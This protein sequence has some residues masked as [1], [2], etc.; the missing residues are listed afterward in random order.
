MRHLRITIGI[1]TLNGPDLLARC[2]ESVGACTRWAQWDNIKVLAVDDGSEEEQLKLTKDAIHRAST[3]YPAMGLELLVHGQRR[4]IAAGWNS[5]TRH[6][7]CDVV[8][9]L[10]N[11][12][13]VTDDWLDVL[14]YS[15]EHNPQLGMVGLNAYTGVTKRQVAEAVAGVPT[16]SWRPDVDF[17]EAKLMDGD[18][19][20]LTS[21]GYAFAFRRKDYDAIGGFDERY[22]CFYEESLPSQE[23]V[24]VRDSGVVRMTTF[25]ALYDR[26][27]HTATVR[28]DGK[29]IAH[30][31][32]LECLSALVNRDPS[33]A[34]LTV[35]E[36]EVLALR[37]GQKWDEMPGA[38]YQVMLSAKRK[39]REATR[40][41]GTWKPVAA[42]VRH[43]RHNDVVHVRQKAGS[44]YVTE[45][46]SMV[47]PNGDGFRVVHPCAFTEESLPRAATI[48]LPETCTVVDLGSYVREWDQY[49][50][51]AES[52]WYL[53]YD[54]EHRP[55]EKRVS[56]KLRR[57][58]DLMSDGGQSFCWL[59]GF[60][61]AEGSTSV[62]HQNYG[63]MMVTLACNNTRAL[64]DKTAKIWMDVMGGSDP[65]ILESRLE[66]GLVHHRVNVGNKLAGLLLRAMCGIGAHAKR[67]PD[68]IYNAPRACKDALLAGY[69]AGDGLEI[70]SDSDRPQARSTLHVETVSRELAA[71]VAV[72]LAGSD[73]RF[74]LQYRPKTR[75]YAMRTINQFVGHR[76]T[77]VVEILEEDPGEFVY[78]LTV[79][80]THVFCAGVG[81]VVVHNCDF[82]VAVRQRGFRCAMASHPLVYH[83]GGATNSEPRHLVASERMAESRAK[84][85]EKW[86]HSPD[87]LRRQMEGSRLPLRCWNSQMR[88]LA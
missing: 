29:V 45:N 79:A 19:S 77:R 73:K 50:E 27:A 20:L 52:M 8:A 41:D 49:R 84:F 66:N 21:C 12:V 53:G 85:L 2:L 60:H 58:I 3:A 69:A 75:S 80:D 76:D 55:C 28:G 51:D 87:E 31:D 72:L 35:R 78:D 88:N 68:F 4:G 6:R 7:E 65:F 13:E 37:D 74:S 64:V 33:A 38:D 44:V 47:V 54:S 25:G 59:L 48:R 86:G 16:H 46:H 67:I 9:L 22:F 30:P 1:P 34:F 83:M 81:P 42:I 26:W 39:Q 71:G 36:C 5:L 40:V 63:A 18:G 61:V 17:C 32:G 57:H 24:L 82:G 70:Q 11:D 43:R 62:A 56:P 10:N 14:V 15:L 23:V